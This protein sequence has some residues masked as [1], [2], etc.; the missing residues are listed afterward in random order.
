MVIQS[1]ET[2]FAHLRD[3]LVSQQY[4]TAKKGEFEIELYSDLNLV[5]ADNSGRNTS[6][7]QIEFEYGLTDHWQWAYYE[8][9]TWDRSSDWERDEFK[10]ETKYRFAESGRLP[11]DIALYAEYKNPDGS[12]HTRSDELELKLILAKHFGPWHFIANGITERK[13][14]AGD[15]WEVAYTLGGSRLLNP[16]TRLGVELKHTL[17][18]ID[19]FGVHQKGHALQ[20]IPGLYY[21]PSSNTRVLIGPAIGLTRAADDLQLK[22]I[23]EVEF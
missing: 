7:H 9:Y 11:V 23:F 5:E 15:H 12:R 6:K 1:K 18:D 13:L 20:V 22:S 8:V 17:G 3:Y 21:S 2:A 19:E 16:R 10:I 14:N 4:Y